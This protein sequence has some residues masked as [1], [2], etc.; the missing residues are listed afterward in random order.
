M[1]N[2]KGVN[3]TQYLSNNKAFAPNTKVSTVN[4]VKTTNFSAVGEKSGI[5]RILAYLL[6]II[7]VILVIL[8]FINFFITPIFRLRPGGPGIIPIPG[9]DD[10]VLFWNTTSAGSILNK[11]LPIASQS[12]GYTINLDVFVE[13][14]LQFATTPRVFFSRGA[15]ANPKPTGDTLLGLYSTYNLV[16]ALLPDTNDLI[17]SVLNKDNNMENIIV[18]NVPIQ[19]PFRLSMV[20]MEQALEVYMNGQLIKT[21]KFAS[22]PMDVKGD[23]Y[24]S[25]GVEINVI[26]VRN[27]KI[28]SR[29]LA[30]AEIR[31]AT[32]SL[33]TAK[34]FGAAPMAGS[35]TSCS[36]ASTT[37]NGSGI[38]GDI[39]SGMDRLSKLSVNTVPDSISK[40]F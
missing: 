1:S 20:V 24:P 21:R 34:D 22:T 29:L 35:T 36:S 19:Q 27:L 5:T 7:V 11:D 2:N 4:L 14:P 37:S 31:Q 33:S 26:K 28:W 40:L 38:T 12:Y 13:N 15:T 30:V 3:I 23:I 25:T 16:A 6:A 9:F 32:P 17:V 10:G 18:P 8:L 39:G